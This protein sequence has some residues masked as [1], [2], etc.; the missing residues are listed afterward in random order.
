MPKHAL[1][2]FALSRR[3]AVRSS[4]PHT[5]WYSVLG[6]PSLVLLFFAS[7]PVSFRLFVAIS[8]GRSEARAQQRPAH[9]KCRASASRLMRSLSCV[10]SL[11]VVLFSRVKKNEEAS[12]AKGSARH[13]T[14]RVIPAR[15]ARSIELSFVRA[16]VALRRFVASHAVLGGGLSHGGLLPAAASRTCRPDVTAP[17]RCGFANGRVLRPPRSNDVDAIH[18]SKVAGLVSTTIFGHPA[19]PKI[20][21]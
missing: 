8:G 2:L 16:L 19:R 1:A 20:G 17:V 15:S 11:F 21:T 18:P 4:A 14:G 3:P 7:L 10:S 9:S 5:V 13:D 6:T 12:S